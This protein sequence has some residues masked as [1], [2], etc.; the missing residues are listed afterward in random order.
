MDAARLRLAA[1]LEELHRMSGSP[2]YQTLAMQGGPPTSTINDW[3]T[4]KSVPREAE[5]LQ[6][7]VDAIGRT[8]A[9]IPPEYLDRRRW[10]GLLSEVRAAETA[11][12]RAG[13]RSGRSDTVTLGSADNVSRTAAAHTEGIR[14]ALP[15]HWQAHGTWFLG[16][17]RADVNPRICVVGAVDSGK[18]TFF[19]LLAQAQ[20]HREFGFTFAYWRLT[21]DREASSEAGFWVRISH[22][23]GLP[24]PLDPR[25]PLEQLPNALAELYQ[26]RAVRTL[27][28]VLDDWDYAQSHP[29]HFVHANSLRHLVRFVH[30][31]QMV[32]SWPMRL[33]LCYV[34]RFP[35]SFYLTSHVRRANSQELVRS[36]GDLAE[37]GFVY[38]R[39]PFLDRE[40][41]TDLLAA[42]GC[43]E[44]YR[45]GVL[46]ACGGWA[47]L[48]EAATRR[49]MDS[50]GWDASAYSGVLEDLELTLTKTLLPEVMAHWRLDSLEAAW[51]R[52]LRDIDAGVDPH[53]RYGLPTAFAS[54]RGA[55]ST[56][57][58]ALPEVLRAFLA[59]PVDLVV[60]LENLCVRFSKHFDRA[61][62]AYPDGLHHFWR[63]SLPPAITYAADAYQVPP[64]NVVIA[65]KSRE[66]V[67][68]VLGPL[69]TGWRA[70]PPGI[71]VDSGHQSEADDKIAVGYIARAAGANPAARFVLLSEDQ[72]NIGVI[73]S[74]D[75]ANL[76]VWT[77]FEAPRGT[78]AA[79][80]EAWTVR[81]NLF[82]AV[83]V[84]RPP[85]SPS[86]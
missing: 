50:G 21:A 16:Q 46:D 79:A 73:R 64:H 59:P 37:R 63:T 62:S 22:L 33:G 54:K 76:V 56:G 53:G 83:G 42:L 26:S 77:P 52:I 5:Q 84:T 70:L 1:Q 80:A 19:R 69:P 57:A 2:S 72:E 8:A 30:G 6:K 44:E 74:L 65:S 75:V 48:L 15:N 40:S 49:V 17:I 23:L 78:A 45:D 47:G 36:S 7:L 13:S 18:S 4:G 20:P 81:E 31:D 29:D 85:V 55:E 71:R 35:S 24:E 25:A 68:E 51:A 3:I 61:P 43:P 27:V 86:R 58:S 41:S 39:F 28:L 11:V 12:R 38:A 32:R 82:P 9:D 34:T 10:R 67:H 66:R 60:D 14:A